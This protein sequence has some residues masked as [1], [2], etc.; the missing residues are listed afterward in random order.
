VQLLTIG[1][2]CKYDSQG[3]RD[4]DTQFSVRWQPLKFTWWGIVGGALW[5]ITGVGA[6]SAVQLAGIGPT[7]PLWSA[8]S[9]MVS[10]VW[11]FSDC[12]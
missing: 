12:D 2:W 3:C 4:A 11:V 5:V 8:L 6:I 9:S 10:P 1:D 7:Q